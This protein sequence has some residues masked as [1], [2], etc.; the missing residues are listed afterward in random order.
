MP[1]RIVPAIALPLLQ[2]GPASRPTV[3]HARTDARQLHRIPPPTM[4]GEIWE[5]HGE[6][7]YDPC[8]DHYVPVTFWRDGERVEPIGRIPNERHFD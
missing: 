1:R 7:N 5:Y 2:V 6:S 8:A 3:H 4:E